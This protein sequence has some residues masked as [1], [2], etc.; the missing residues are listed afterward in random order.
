MHAC[1]E[2]SSIVRKRRQILTN[3]LR[4]LIGHSMSP[5]LYWKTGATIDAQEKITIR[6]CI[7]E[8]IK[9]EE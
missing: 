8:E 9:S 7:V 5:V 3:R 4:R 2:R 1:G 6:G